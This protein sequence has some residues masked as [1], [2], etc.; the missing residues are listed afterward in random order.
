MVNAKKWS[1]NETA[2]KNLFCKLNKG[3]KSVQ[4]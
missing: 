1:Y 4:L 2:T 3:S